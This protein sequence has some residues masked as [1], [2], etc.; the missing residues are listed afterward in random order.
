MLEEQ[1][2]YDVLV[3]FNDSARQ[4]VET[5]ARTLIDTPTGAKVPIGQVAE[6]R[7]RPGA[8]HDQPRERAAPHHHSSQRRRTRSGQR[9]Q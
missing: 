9:H 4:S 7:I 8:E 2:T 6:V 5:I 1:R 3:R